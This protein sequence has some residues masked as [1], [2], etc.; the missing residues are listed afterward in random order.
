MNEDRAGLAPLGNF[1]DMSLKGISYLKPLKSSYILLFGVP[2]PGHQTIYLNKWDTLLYLMML[3]F[4]VDLFLLNTYKSYNHKSA[5][6]QE[7]N[8]SMKFTLYMYL[9]GLLQLPYL[10]LCLWY[11]SF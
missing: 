3:K 9:D 8:G 5:V 11:G 10:M 2:P 7:I 6:K 4:Y 1:N